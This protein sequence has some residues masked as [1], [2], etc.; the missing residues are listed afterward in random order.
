[1]SEDIAIKSLDPMVAPKTET[2]ADYVNNL[3]HYDELTL[4]DT[5]PLMESHDD[6]EARFVAEYMQTFLAF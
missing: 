3:N 5:I 1:M 4:S 2:L 6:R